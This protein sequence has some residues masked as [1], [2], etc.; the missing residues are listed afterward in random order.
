MKTN[1]ISMLLRGNPYPGRGILLGRSAD[2]KKAVLA[3]FIMGRSANSRN[4]IFEKTDDG[5]RASAFDPSKV[6]DPSLI[7]YNPVRFLG[8]RTIV[9]N[10]DQTD[11]IYDYL[12]SGRSFRD[13][14]LTR[15]FEPD[16]PNY[17]PRISGLIERDGSY[18]LSM[19][20][21]AVGD[22]SCC[23]RC[24]F[25]Y[26]SAIPGVGHFISTYE[27]DG[28]PLPSFDGE[29]IPIHIDIAGG[30][31]HFANTLWDSLNDDN[32]VSLYARETEISTGSACD[33]I[34]NKNQ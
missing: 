30:L 9:T 10:G 27:T 32:K 24:F 22:P 12:S 34:I 28:D 11:T 3:Y 7:L 1:D 13:A 5:I 8:G 29:P 14:L 21:T 17:T 26:S 4:R 19:L 15:E 31:E 20:K 23:L 16:E 18:S 2:D 25:E 6:S 33:I